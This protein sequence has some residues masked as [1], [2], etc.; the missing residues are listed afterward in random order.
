MMEIAV[1]ELILTRIAL[2]EQKS[3]LGPHRRSALV[4]LAATKKI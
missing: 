3:I 1:G 2:Q 4:L